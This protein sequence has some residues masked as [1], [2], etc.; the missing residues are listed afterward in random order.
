MIRGNSRLNNAMMLTTHMNANY[1]K[2]Y[3][4]TISQFPDK[5]MLVVPTRHLWDDLKVIDQFVLGNGSFGKI[6][7]FRYTHGSEQYSRVA[8]R[9]QRKG[10]KLCVVLLKIRWRLI[11]ICCLQLPI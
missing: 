7:G 4:K 1:C 9:Y 8:N 6:E 11:A 2:Y 10:R 3:H 5:E